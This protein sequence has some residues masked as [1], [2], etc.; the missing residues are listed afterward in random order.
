MSRYIEIA[1]K[2]RNVCCVARMLEEQAPKTCVAVSGALPLE[3]DVFHAKHAGNEIFTLV[4]P[5]DENEPGPENRTH[6][7]D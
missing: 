6:F 3:G 1:L 7:R 5:F 2:K 4:P